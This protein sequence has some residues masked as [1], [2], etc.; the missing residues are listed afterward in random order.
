M[1]R[2]TIKDIFRKAIK[3]VWKEENGKL[4]KRCNSLGSMEP[5][6]ISNLVGKKATLKILLLKLSAGAIAF[7]KSTLIYFT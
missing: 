3:K 4:V 1:H 2:I 6:S 7:L 5:L